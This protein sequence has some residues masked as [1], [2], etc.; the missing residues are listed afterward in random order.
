[1]KSTA[2]NKQNSERSAMPVPPLAGLNLQ[3]IPNNPA[4]EFICNPVIFY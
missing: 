3:N 1:M 4:K 2:A